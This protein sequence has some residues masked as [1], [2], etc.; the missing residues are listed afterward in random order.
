M[1][2][3]CSIELAT[4]YK[5]GPQIARVLSEDWCSRELY[6]PACDSDRVTRAR[7]NTP[8]IDFTC[9]KC[10]QAF[11]LKSLRAWNPRKVPDA[12]YSA[13]I[14][15]IRT[16]NAPHLLLLQYTSQWCISN[17]LLIPRMFFTETIIEKRKPLA[18][19][20]R[21]AGWVGCNIL[22]RGIPEDGKIGIISSGRV[23]PKKQVRDEFDRVRALGNLPPSQRG[24]TVDVLNAVRELGKSHFSLSDLYALE[25]ALQAAHPHNA[26]VRAKIRQ[27]LQVLRNLGLLEFTGHGSYM[28]RS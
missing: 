10:E 23:E 12:A 5:A 24:W 15:A 4:A 9:P 2:L 7:S 16:D 22:L 28:L 20:A 13:M 14:R 26:N 17:L 18:T 1:N 8:G 27:Q 3:Q 6:C 25:G 21:R 11:Q 19:T